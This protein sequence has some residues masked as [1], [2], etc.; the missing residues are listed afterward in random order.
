VSLHASGV[1]RRNC[2]LARASQPTATD[3]TRFS[4]RGE[5]AQL[6]VYLIPHRVDFVAALGL[7]RHG[8]RGL[9]VKRMEGS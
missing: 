4:H 2:A 6:L 3:G 8:T 1:S 9:G 7:T 5:F